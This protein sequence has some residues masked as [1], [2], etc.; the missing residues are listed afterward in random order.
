MVSILKASSIAGTYARRLAISHDWSTIIVASS[1]SKS[2]SPPKIII[3]IRQN[4][5]EIL[6]ISTVS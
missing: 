6:K 4:L 1:V 2:K 5:F 3:C